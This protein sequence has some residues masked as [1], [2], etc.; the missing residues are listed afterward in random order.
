MSLS[1]WVQCIKYI[2]I[3]QPS[4]LSIART[5]SHS[6]LLLYPLNTTSSFCPNLIIDNDC[7]TFCLYEF[8]YSSHFSDFPVAQMIKN[9][10][11]MQESR[12][13]SLDWE[14][15]LEKGMAIHSSI[16]A[17]RIPWTEKSGRLQTMASQRVGHDWATNTHTHNSHFL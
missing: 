4:P 6:R 11:V 3:V 9:L 5:F 7:F 14:V 12:V 16:L 8:D 17:C 1:L 10:P 15:P 2:C 13:R